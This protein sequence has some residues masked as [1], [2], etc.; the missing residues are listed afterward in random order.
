[1]CLSIDSFSVLE[2]EGHPAVCVNSGVVQKPQPEVAGKLG[3]LPVLRFQELQ[4]ILHLC[5]AG[6]FIA[7]LS[8]GCFVLS[9]GGL[10]AFLVFGLVEGYGGVF[11][12]RLCVI[13][14]ED[15]EKIL[16]RRKYPA[17]GFS[18]KTQRD[19]G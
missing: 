10:K 13:W 8:V 7:E 14:P 18:R 3:E 5:L 2:G 15:I 11:R 19:F 6:L 17:G 9:L 1:M 12:M 16:C 4:E